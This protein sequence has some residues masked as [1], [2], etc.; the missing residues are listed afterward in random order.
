VTL[1]QASPTDRDLLAQIADGDRGALHILFT[2]HQPWLAARVRGR[3]ADPAIVNEVVNDSFLAVWQQPRRY[4]G[5]GEVAA[6][7]W[8]IAI[9]TTIVHDGRAAGGSCG[10]PP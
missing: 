10:R 7:L 3:C 9:R 5:D 4:K 8:G 2:R 1:D 6:W